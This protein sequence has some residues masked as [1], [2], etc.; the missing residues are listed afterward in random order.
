MKKTM[1]V[2]MVFLV[3]SF[4]GFGCASKSTITTTYK[5][6]DVVVEKLTDEASF[7]KAQQAAIASHA[8]LIKA[9]PVVATFQTTNGEVIKI[10]SQLIPEYPVVRQRKNQVVEGLKAVV[11]STP[12][13]I[14]AG[15]WSASEII[16]RST[17]DVTASGMSSVTTTANSHN[18]TDISNA[19][20][21]IDRSNTEDNSVAINDD[22]SVRIDDDHSD[23]SDNS[24]VDS[25]DQ[26]ADPT[27]V[28]Q[29]DYNDPVLVY[30]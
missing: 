25:H 26:T 24:V 13:A 12:L 23:H 30:P 14:I 9:P 10:H 15:G 2:L 6:G 27:V 19:D 1:I 17:G 28:T 18:A 29:P 7:N 22:H 11:T 4:L 21:S 16:K 20:G 3:F 5:N 8:E